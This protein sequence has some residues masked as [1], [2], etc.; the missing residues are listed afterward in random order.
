[1]YS[2]IVEHPDKTK[3]DV[4]AMRHQSSYRKTLDYLL[5]VSHVCFD[6]YVSND[7]VI[8]DGTWMPELDGRGEDF[9]AEFIEEI[10]NVV[11][12]IVKQVRNSGM[13]E[14]AYGTKNLRGRK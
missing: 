3:D 6:L 8:P 13:I 2:N 1:M 7:C 12:D 10:H 4:W 14:G 11:K 9:M 5:V